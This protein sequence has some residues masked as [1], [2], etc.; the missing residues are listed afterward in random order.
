MENQTDFGPVDK[1]FS[2]QTSRNVTNFHNPGA[3]Y[4]EFSIASDTRPLAY[5]RLCDKCTKTLFFLPYFPLNHV[6]TGSIGSCALRCRELSM[7]PTFLIGP[8]KFVTSRVDRETHERS[9]TAKYF[10]G[11]RRDRKFFGMTRLL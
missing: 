5:K 9:F 11:L 4:Y 10:A 1:F 2:G 6:I 8:L 7:Q 3:G